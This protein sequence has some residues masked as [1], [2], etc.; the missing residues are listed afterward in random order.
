M[1]MDCIEIVL[2]YEEAIIEANIGVERLWDDLHHRSYFLTDLHKVA[3]SLCCSSSIRNVHK[4]LNPF[5]PTHIF[6]EDK[7]ANILQTILVNISKNPNIV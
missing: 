1:D 5:S 6:P 2:P 3:L 7:M 4:I